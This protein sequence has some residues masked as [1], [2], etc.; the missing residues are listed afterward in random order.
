[1]RSIRRRPGMVGVIS[2]ALLSTM[3]SSAAFSGTVQLVRNINTVHPPQSSNPVALGNLNGKL[4]FGA[5]DDSGAGLWSTDGTGA[6]T[7]RL[8]SLPGFGIQANEPTTTFL[9]AGSQAYFVVITG[10]GSSSVWITDGTATGTRDVMDFS[11]LTTAP[12]GLLAIWNNKLIFNAYDATGAS[13]IYSSDGTTTGTHA[14]T[15]FT[16]LNVGFVHGF[17]AAGAKF[18][19]VTMDSQFG[20]HIWVSDGTAAGTHEVV[21]G[22][23]GSSATSGAIYNPQ[24]LQLVGNYV[25]YASQGLLWRI[26][27]ATDTISSVVAASGT[28]GFGPPGVSSAVLLNMG[29]FVMFLGAGTGVIQGFDLWRSDGTATGTYKIAAVTPHPTF[30][31]NQFP[32]FFKV[33]GNAVYIAD[34]GTHG[35]QLWGSDGTTANTI[36]LINNV[37]VNP[38]ED[39]FPVAFLHVV[40]GNTAYLSV[41]DGAGTL[42]RSLFRTDG[43]VAG[44]KRLG[45]LPS[46]S[47]TEAGVTQVAGDV[48]TVY[49]GIENLDAIFSIYRY[50]PANDS[51]SQVTSNLTPVS[52]QEFFE[53]N[54]RL[55]F[56]TNDVQLGVEPWTTDGTAAGTHLIKDIN[57]QTADADSS[58]DEFVSFAGR[59]AFVA[60]NGVAGR[61]LWISDG[62]SSGT[63][64]L[65][66]INPGAASSNPNH[67]FSANGVLYFFATDA[68]GTSKF[69]RLASPTASLEQLAVLSPVPSVPG[70][71]LKDG[72]VAIGTQIFFA[73]TDGVS[74]LELW[75]SDGTAQGTHLTADIATGVGD[76]IP[77]E[78]TVMGNRV[79]FSAFGLQG[80]EL[81]TSDGTSSG[82]FQVADIAPGN[83]SSSPNGLFAFNGNLFFSADD[84]LHGQELWMSNGTTAGTVLAADIVPGATASYAL[85]LGVINGRLLL[86]TLVTPDLTSY[87]IQLW[88]TD[89]TS[90]G[91]TQVG[92]SSFP[93]ALIPF[94]NGSFAFFEGQDAAGLEPWVSDG[95]AAGTHVLK[96]INPAG[97]SSPAWFESFLGSTLFE[98]SDPNLG[99]MLWQTDGTTAGTTMIGAIPRQPP[100]G[101]QPATAARHRL[102]VGPNFF[103]AANDR[104]TG[105]EL[106]VL[107]H[108]APAVVDDSA[109][110]SNDAS[111][112]IDV[113][114][115]DSATD[116]AVDA[117]SIQL[118]TN[119]AHGSAVVQGG[120]IQYTPTAGFAGTDTFQYT[121][122]DAQGVESSAATVTVTVTAAALP[123]ASHGGGGAL[124]I[125]SVLGLLLLLLMR[126]AAN[127]WLGVRRQNGSW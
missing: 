38:L 3:F 126:H 92:T 26:D 65:A 29:G 110:S 18:Y 91:T 66:D 76:S 90:A 68:S 8:Q 73:A 6:G 62:T 48:N 25:L 11:S 88:S 55:F 93:T 103:F 20:L 87:A 96:D 119:P 54:G 61:E 97:N 101:P 108:S 81:W 40:V 113:L 19:F 99:E 74:G 105:T 45:G 51:G 117:N 12:A 35:Q 41:S 33:G 104:A 109:S 14:L 34:D 32:V 7:V 102:T 2:A 100:Q 70:Y 52:L 4:L 5:T 30:D 72:G 121:V 1:M 111:I 44:T 85:P 112:V 89:G 31:E 83:A 82:T 59:L 84:T 106:Y 56:S 124:T 50:L 79:Y 116:S 21:N 42:T 58:P 10:N 24:S 125:Q 43:T 86:E 123:P 49:F 122:K 115:N 53:L 114:A 98:V 37:T 94:V 39:P 69:F 95:T 23:D 15:G 77:C 127:F 22:L 75:T 47:V 107:T 13:Q 57:P 118:T 64:L 27:T 46:V 78:L 63:K 36:A 9:V 60:D 28:P 17:L 71:C 80:N 67:L 120:K 16:G